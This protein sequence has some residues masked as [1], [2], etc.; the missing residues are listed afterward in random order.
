MAARLGEAEML[1]VQEIARFEEAIH[2]RPTD[3]S[4]NSALRWTALAR[5]GLPAVI[6]RLRREA[7][8][9]ARLQPLLR[10]PRPDHFLFEGDRLT[11]LVDFGA[12]GVDSPSADLARLLTE[13]SGPDPS[14]RAEAL[15]CYE[16][17][18]PLDPSESARIEVFADSAAWL[19]PARWIRWHYLESR[20][21]DDPDAVRLGLDR[22]IGRLFERLAGSAIADHLRSRASASDGPQ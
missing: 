20:R 17:I 12:M 8:V 3:A 13:W 7:P 19:G 14:S 6:A 5:R 9:P 4:R 2:L 1:L 11:G 18:R 15:D 16:S 10:D 21:F 22:T